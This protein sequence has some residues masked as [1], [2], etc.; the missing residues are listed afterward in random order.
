MKILRA[1]NDDV[2]VNGVGFLF[3]KIKKHLFLL[4]S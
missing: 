4:C 2:T 1:Q 3:Q